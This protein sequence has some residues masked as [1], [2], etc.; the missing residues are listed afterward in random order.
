VTGTKRLTI[1]LAIAI[2]LLV[3]GGGLAMAASGANE[4][5]VALPAT[6]SLAVA[7]VSTGAI[8]DAA[9]DGCDGQCGRYVN[10]GARG[11]CSG[12]C[13]GAGTGECT[14]DCAGTCNGVCTQECDGECD[15]ECSGDCGQCVAECT[16]DCLGTSKA[17][18]GGCGRSAGS[19]SAN[20]GGC[21]SCDVVG[22][23]EYP[24]NSPQATTNA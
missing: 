24:A 19:S 8:D 2:P 12:D 22:L 4:S 9:C 11:D 16:G 10:G 5:T 13:T 3:V 6:P 21:S 14:G 17:A 20:S 1:A 23:N 18:R 7:P 15:S